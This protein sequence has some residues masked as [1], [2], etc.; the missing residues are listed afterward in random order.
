MFPKATFAGERHASRRHVSHQSN[1]PFLLRRSRHDR[2]EAARK[3][4]RFGPNGD[5]PTLDKSQ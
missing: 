1:G 5:S 3:N 4:F 2:A